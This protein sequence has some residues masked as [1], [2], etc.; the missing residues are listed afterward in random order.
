M[1]EKTTATA[2]DAKVQRLVQRLLRQRVVQ[3]LWYRRGRQDG[4]TWAV[5]R[6]SLEELR[7]LAEEMPEGAAQELESLGEI[8]P[9][10]YPSVN[11]KQLLAEWR[12]T[13]E[14]EGERESGE[15]DWRAYLQ[16]WQHACCDLWRAAKPSLR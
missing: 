5:E 10:L 3:E 14:A 11:A 8:D 1:T 7:M 12:R 9:A 16:G 13:D 6:A 2:G 4:E 15:A